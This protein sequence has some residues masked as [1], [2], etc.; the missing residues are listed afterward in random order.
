MRI[1]KGDNLDFFGHE[2]ACITGQD[3][4]A[5]APVKKL[6]QVLGINHKLA[7]RK[8]K[9]RDILGGKILNVE[10]DD[11]RLR[12]MFCLPLKKLHYWLHLINPD[13]VR[14]EI[15][16]TLLEMRA[17]G[18]IA[19]SHCIRYGI[20]INPRGEAE[21]MESRVRESIEK[22]MGHKLGDRRY[23]VQRR[24]ELLSVEIALLRQFIK[25]PPRFRDKAYECIA[26]ALRRYDE[27]LVNFKKSADEALL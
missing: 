18:G 27:W 1:T 12:K 3:S 9:R 25:E 21:E 17:E 4:D 16:E 26:V 6:C 22:Q 23:P 20:A 8:V 7:I 10:G 14:P 11:G 15:M 24:F 2:I 19:I 13:S 5:Y